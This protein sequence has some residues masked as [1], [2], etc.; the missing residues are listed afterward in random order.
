MIK[1]I[2]NNEIKNAVIYCRVSSKEQVEEGNSLVSQERICREYAVKEG[3]QVVEVFIEKGESAKTAERKELKRLMSFCT[4]KKGQIQAVIA[5]KVDRI[6]RSI[7]DYSHI[8]LLLKKYGVEIKS[9][10]EYFEDTP[11]GR[12]MENIIANVGQFDNDVRTERSIGGMREATQEGRYVWM[13]PIGYSNVKVN[14]K[15]TIAPDA[16]APFVRETFELIAERKY[17]TEAI[18]LAMTK[19]GLLSKKGQP[20]IRSVFYASLRSPLYKG[21]INK[22]GQ[23][24]QGK[25]DP[26]VSVEL[27]DEVQDIL[28]GRTHKIKHYLNENPDF[29]LRRFVVNEDGK[30]LTGYW[31]KGNCKKYPYYSFHLPGT[32][33]RKEVLEQKFRDFLK[34]FEFDHKNLNMMRKYL[35]K[36]YESRVKNSID[37]RQMINERIGTI[38]DQIDNLIALQ[39]A[40]TIST[41]ILA[42]RVGKLETEQ[43]ELKALLR[44]RS[45]DDVN[46]SE[47]MKFAAEVL[48]HPDLLWQK[49][50]LE[51]RRKLQEF[52]FPQGVVFN[53]ENFRTPKLCSL[54]KV[55]QEFMDRL[56]V[57]VPSDYIGKN[58]VLSTNQ[59]PSDL[60]VFETKEFWGEVV[61]DIK[62]LQAILFAKS[63]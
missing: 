1:T 42:D 16:M 60:K 17:S 56:S 52:D 40:G 43:N 37:S 54:Y 11:A 18:R 14:G 35:V 46:L 6:S 53:G 47:L 13:A 32:T 61:N 21:I 33:I 29:P 45:D 19:K 38:S 24:Y 62:R 30:Q 50:S 36:H 15:S 23:T 26:I 22:F 44:N 51:V 10:T 39:V 12:F 57:R 25:F 9:V 55:K 34:Q 59:P 63:L 7:A 2:Q 5:Y 3:Y 20:I 41:S 48:K 27:F 28:A 58:S 49:S 4:A 8:R 31:S